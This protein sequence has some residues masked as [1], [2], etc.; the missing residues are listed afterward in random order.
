M[1]TMHPVQS[2]LEAHAFD[3]E[4][5]LGARNAVETCLALQPGERLTLI[6]D[7][8]TRD[9]AASLFAAARKAGCRV[10]PFILEEE[11]PRPLERFPERILESVAGSDATL[12][13][14][15]PQPGEITSRGELIGLVET[16][17]TRYAHMVWIS[18]EIMKQS[19]RADYREVDD[20][21]RRLLARLRHAEQVTVTSPGGTN[22]TATFDP[23]WVWIKTSGIISPEY[24]SN[25]PGGEVWTCPRDV[26]G[27][28]VADGAVGDFL[29]PKYGDI[30]ATPLVL[31][32]ADGY[33]VSAACENRELL[34]D[35]ATY[36]KQVENGDRVGEF[37]IGTNIGISSLIGNLLQDEKVPG[38]HIAFGNTCANLTGADWTASTH[39]DAISRRCDV[40]ADGEQ[41]MSGGR[42][43]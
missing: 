21:S 10:D 25:L 23:T 36:C 5:A 7:H 35:F 3:P 15:Q 16:Q 27:T 12:S 30:S 8:A 37:A 22:L 9:I 17:R 41:I 11:G 19:M 38:V 28:F 18:P 20:L 40:W 42:F 4:L 2:L 33:L 39:I 14:F 32:I 1:A 31:E 43:L 34:E 6:T 26:N 24:W 13:C 29:C